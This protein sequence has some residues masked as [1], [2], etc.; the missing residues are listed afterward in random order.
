MTVPAPASAPVAAGSLALAFQEVFTAAVRIRAAGLPPDPDEPRPRFRVPDAV[1]FNQHMR[2]VIAR[3]VDGAKRSGYT[4]RDIEFAMLAAVGFLDETILNSGD[5]VFADWHR[6][7]LSNQLFFNQNAGVIFFDNLRN[8]LGERD[9]PTLAGVLD[10]YRLAL[11]LGFR[12]KLAD[13]T[14]LRTLAAQTGQKISRTRGYSETLFPP[15]TVSVAQPLSVAVDPW[16][17]RLLVIAIGLICLAVVLFVG[18]ELNLD[19]YLSQLRALSG[20]QPG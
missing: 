18:F 7:T 1:S 9:S 16:N 19:G 11:L 8:L 15:E 6:D 12:G 2:Q 5:P 4:D 14:Q 20:G 13:G 10:V 3:S 17:R